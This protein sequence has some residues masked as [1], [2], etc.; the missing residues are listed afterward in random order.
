MQT[1]R[2][3]ASRRAHLGSEATPDGE[4]EGKQSPWLSYGAAICLEIALRGKQG[5]GKQVELVAVATQSAARSKFWQRVLATG[6]S[7]WDTDVASRVLRW[8]C[9]KIRAALASDRQRVAAS[10]VRSLD[11]RTNGYDRVTVGAVTATDFFDR[12]R[13]ASR[14]SAQPTFAATEYAYDE[15]ATTRPRPHA[16]GVARLVRRWGLEGVDGYI[17]PERAK[18]R[19]KRERDGRPDP[20]FLRGLVHT[21]VLPTQTGSRSDHYY[22]LRLMRYLTVGETLLAA[23]DYSYGESPL[24]AALLDEDC[25]TAVKACCAIGRGLHQVS[26]QY[27]LSSMLDP[28]MSEWPAGKPFRYASAFSGIDMGAASYDACPGLGTA[29]RLEHVFACECDKSLHPAL[30][31]AWGDYGLTADRI[32]PDAATLATAAAPLGRVDLLTITPDCRNF[33]RR[34]HARSREL[35]ADDLAVFHGSLRYVAAH[36]PTFVLIENV[37]EPCVVEPMSCII[38]AITTHAWELVVLCPWESFGIPTRRRRA[39]WL[40]RLL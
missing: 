30:L 36:R 16:K 6:A 35:Q 18:A 33:S 17:V 40:G 14:E 38:G 32:F 1:H 23:G 24:S 19:V 37:A 8:H 13:G 15:A 7:H 31:R 29:R 28:V 25:L 10:L 20:E 39:Y 5:H 22:S 2:R 4:H 12:H 9:R 27:A 21:K 3:L 26:T 11:R 34:N